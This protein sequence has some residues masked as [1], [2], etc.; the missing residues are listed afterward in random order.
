M[1][2]MNWSIPT[3]HQKGQCFATKLK[4]VNYEIF[5]R[6]T[7]TKYTR[8]PLSIRNILPIEHLWTPGRLKCKSNNAVFKKARKPNLL[9][10]NLIKKVEDTVISIRAAGGVCL[11]SKSSIWREK[12]LEQTKKMPWGSMVELYI[13]RIDGLEKKKK[14]WNVQ[15]L[16]G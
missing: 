4:K 5:H 2:G 13:W 14:K 10:K 6:K 12:L 11:G 7:Y 1:L 9:G 8:F 16:R 15:N 3:C